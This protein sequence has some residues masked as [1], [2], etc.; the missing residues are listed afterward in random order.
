MSTARAPSGY[1]L[2]AVVAA[3]QATLETLRTEHGQVIET[4][5]ECIEAL[6]AEGVDV[7]AIITRLVQAALDARANAAAAA[8]RIADL[9]QRRDR[10]RRHEAMCRGTI[11][12]IMQALD[13]RSFRDAEFGLSLRDGA[14]RVVITDAAALPGAYVQVKSVTTPDTTL[15]RAA[16]QAGGTVAG[17]VLSNASPVLQVRST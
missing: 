13:L 6:A 12:Q 5:G 17:A 2:Q 1:V 10:F 4:D 7:G 15:I 8:E 14:P 11:V 3:A 9:A 16:L